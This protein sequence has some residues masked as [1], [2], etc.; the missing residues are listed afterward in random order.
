MTLNN[1]SG[2]EFNS[3][4]F[5]ENQEFDLVNISNCDGIKF[6]ACTFFDNTT[7]T[8]EISEYA[9]FNVGRSKDIVL[10]DCIVERNK[11]VYFCNQQKA[12]E[13]INTRVEKNTFSRGDYKE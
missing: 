13:L 10:K 9:L 2:F 4:E 1:S 5:A 3:C 7:G 8:D 6:T 11:S 12:V